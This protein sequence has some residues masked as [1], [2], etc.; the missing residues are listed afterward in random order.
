MPVM[1]LATNQRYYG[2]EPA[3]LLQCAARVLTRIAGLPPERARVSARSLQQDFALD[4]IQARALVD[5]FIQNGLLQ[6][7]AE[8][9]NDFAVTPRF[10][11]VAA[12]RVVDPMSR[13]KARQM[14]ASA[15]KVAE[16]INR[17]WTRNPLEIDA[18]A[19]SG[20][21]MSR[22]SHVSEITFGIVVRPR[23]MTRRWTLWR[24]ASKSDGASQIRHAFCDLSSF[25]N[26]YIAV[27]SQGLIRPF[28]V[29]Y[30]AEAFE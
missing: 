2:F 19:V 28:S 5:D 26:A 8:Y 14:V 6:R 30:K 16:R 11:E 9:A 27:D 23:P 10:M 13:S 4:T 12:A 25:V 1:T 24:R 3:H 21:F 22:S 15:A 20:S 17:Q 29:V 18:L 7:H